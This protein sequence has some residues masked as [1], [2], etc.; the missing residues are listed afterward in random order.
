MPA[1]KFFDAPA[2]PRIR[3]KAAIQIIRPTISVKTS[4]Q[5]TP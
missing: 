5:P 2:G 1:C 4:L 3:A